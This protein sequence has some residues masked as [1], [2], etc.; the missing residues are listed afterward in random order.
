MSEDRRLQAISG[1]YQQEQLDFDRQ[2]ISFRHQTL[3]PYFKG[4]AGLELG[5][6]DGV[7][8][9][10]LVADFDHL[11]VV[12]GVAELLSQIPDQPNLTKVHSLFENF[13]PS[14]RFDT[15]LMDH[16]LEHVHSPV[17]LLTRVRRWLSPGGQILIGVPNADSIHRLAAVKMGLL[18]NATDLNQRDYSLGHRRVYTHQTLQQELDDAGLDVIEMG[19]IFL[20]P[21][22]NQQIEDYWTEEMIKGFYALGRDFPQNAAEIFVV[23]APR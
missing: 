1:W 4:R 11:T 3:R 12:E 22:S 18:K 19:G 5:P 21:L 15:I 23:A 20:K 10:F 9:N 6:A 2:L 16:V 7:M 14:S 13:N 17:S 8:T